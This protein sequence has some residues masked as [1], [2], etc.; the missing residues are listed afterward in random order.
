[1]INNLTNQLAASNGIEMMGSKIESMAIKIDTSKINFNIASLGT[2]MLE[3][4]EGLDSKEASGKDKKLFIDGRSFRG[5]V[6]RL[7][8]LI[9]IASDNM[10]LDKDYYEGLTGGFDKFLKNQEFL[11]DKAQQEDIDEKRKNKVKEKPERSSRDDDTD[12]GALFT[13][14]GAGGAIA[15][16]LSGIAASQLQAG[17]IYANILKS[18]TVLP[19]KM[20]AGLAKSVGLF[21]G[22]AAKVGADT[23]DGKPKKGLF[24]GIAKK[25]DDLKMGFVAKFEKFADFVRNSKVGQGLIKF[26]DDAM[27]VFNGLKGIVSSVLAP[28]QDLSKLLGT[29]GQATGLFTFFKA[30]GR[31]FLPISIIMGAIDIFKGATA[32]LESLDAD[33]SFLEKAA[34]IFKGGIKGAIQGI[35]GAP[36]DLLKD[37][38]SWILGKLGF[39]DAEKFLDSFS[40]TDVFGKIVD[41][42]MPFK[43]LSKSI[44]EKGFFGGVFEVIEDR[45]KK[46]GQIVSDVWEWL[47]DKLS[48]IGISFGDDGV[49]EPEGNM[50]DDRKSMR[51]G[52]GPQQFDLNEVTK[53]RTRG[54][55]KSM[56]AEQDEMRSMQEAKAATVGSAM[57]YADQKQITVNN[58]SSSSMVAAANMP[59]KTAD[60]G[61]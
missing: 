22:G 7:N 47:K 38:V 40:F 5:I 51:N 8:T 43:E 3:M 6:D 16:I 29:V 1:M 23:P 52:Q 53:A 33:A 4:M 17:K 14:L 36:L 30:L 45:F 49:E 24:D 27:R 20:V 57:A 54:A 13:L 26:S 18:I 46:I 59:D 11:K 41:F 15:G 32:E 48:F 55:L 60:T 2:M 44:E 61:V 21:K 28:I 37:G 12:F 50:S 56:K 42:F 31:V 9:Q 34:A 58:S 19:F 25:F 35:I 39:D 10:K